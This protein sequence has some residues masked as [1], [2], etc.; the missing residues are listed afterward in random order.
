MPNLKVFFTNFL[1][2]KNISDDHIREFTEIHLQRLTA[3]NPGGIYSTM[4]TDTTTVY[5][6]YFGSISDEDLKFSL[7]QGCTI[8]MNAALKGFIQTVQQ[9]EGIIKGTWG[10][11]S[12][13]Y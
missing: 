8:S 9:K 2:T 7:Q 12:A 4:I 5:T 1:D 10:K 13:Q 3:N 11:A 6:A